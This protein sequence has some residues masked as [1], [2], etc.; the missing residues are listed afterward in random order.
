MKKYAKYRNTKV[1]YDGIKFD[2][3]KERDRYI[4]LRLLEKQ[5]LIHDL[6]CQPSFTLQPTFKKN[7]KTYRAIKY[8]ADFMYD[9]HET[10]ETIV[11][12]VKTIGTMT[13]KY[14][15]KKKLFEYKYKHLTIKEIM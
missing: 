13:D 9:D 1:V 14:K 2:S 8:L 15:I 12:D 10:G 3:K 7:G 11:E 5:G 4:V 6:V